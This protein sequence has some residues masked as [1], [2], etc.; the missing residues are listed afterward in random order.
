MTITAR[1]T[2]TRIRAIATLVAKLDALP[3]AVGE[4]H[5]AIDLGDPNAADR[6][7]AEDVAGIRSK[8][9]HSDPTADAALKAVA[10][11][12]RWLADVEDNLA[13]L[14]LAAGNLCDVV[15]RWVRSAVN[16]EPHPRCSGGSGHGVADWTKPDCDNYRSYSV[17]ADGSFHYRGDGLCDACRMR[18]YRFER[19]EV[20]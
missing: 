10:G 6:P 9:G 18:K 2:S 4:I 7:R 13:T 15:S 3:L 20:A 11:H 8:G 14:A 5:R 12:D 16:E 1:Q 17:A 19:A